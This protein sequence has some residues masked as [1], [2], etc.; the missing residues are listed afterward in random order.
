MRQWTRRGLASRRVSYPRPHAS[1]SPGRKFSTITSERAAR[2]ARIA[3][4][5]SVS[6]SST[7]D[8]LLRLTAR[9][10]TASSPANG[11]PQRRVSS[12]V[13]GR[14]TLITSAPRSARIIVASG[15]ARIRV[16]SRTRTPASGRASGGGAVMPARRRGRVVTHAA[17]RRL[18]NAAKPSWASAVVRCAAMARAERVLAEAGSRPRRSWSSRLAARTAVGPAGQDGAQLVV[19]RRVEVGGV[20]DQAVHEPDLPGPLG[21]EPAAAGEQGPGV[22]LADL[23]DHERRDHR[24]D[25]PEAGLREAERRSRLGHHDVRDRAQA[26]PAA[27][28]AALDARD[29]G[30]RAVVDGPE[31]V[32]GRQRVPLVGRL[33]ERHRGAHPG[34]VRPG[35]EQRALAG[36]DHGPELLGGLVPQGIERRA[37]V[38]DGRRVEGVADLGPSEGHPGDDAVRAV[39]IDAERGGVHRRYGTAAA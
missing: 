31:H 20:G 2:R 23:R 26:H 30:D 33:V 6:R 10:Y 36:Q 32:R 3:R 19:H 29:D 21:V 18:E 17:G 8:R 7:T 11:G 34:D 27:Q 14:S 1:R 35:A 16:R 12:P 22:R 4:P 13:P 24:G 5:S 39:A 25:D 15:P 38:R 37:Q 9:K 28:R